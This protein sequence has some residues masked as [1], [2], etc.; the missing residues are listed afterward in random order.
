LPLDIIR[1]QIFADIFHSILIMNRRYKFALLVLVGAYVLFIFWWQSLGFP[2]QAQVCEYAKEGAIPH[3][4]TYGFL[5][6][7]VQTTLLWVEKFHDSLLVFGTLVLAVGVV[8]QIH[9]AR[10]SSERQLRA[11]IV[12]MPGGVIR[13]SRRRNLRFELRPVVKN[14]GQ[15]PAYKVRISGHAVVRSAILG[16]DEDYSADQ[17][18]PSPSIM[19]LGSGQEM[20]SFSVLDHFVSKG[21]LRSLMRGDR[22]R[23][24]VYGTVYYEDTF[25]NERRTNFNYG[26]VWMPRRQNFWNAS[27]Y[28]NHST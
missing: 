21:D 9:D 6:A 25:G 1:S 26:I 3:C 24:Y 4:A 8:F 11:Y 15:T 7:I 18:G 23:L 16:P 28:N 13:Q 20:I 22:L 5:A 12:V 17:F 14:T 27:R 10:A 2:T 19:T